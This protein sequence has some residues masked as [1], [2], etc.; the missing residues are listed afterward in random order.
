MN[1]LYIYLLLLTLTYFLPIP[2]GAESRKKSS[3]SNPIFN[4]SFQVDPSEVAISI[5]YCTVFFWLVLGRPR[6]LSSVDTHVHACGGILFSLILRACLRYDH[7]LLQTSSPLFNTA[8]L[9]TGYLVLAM[10]IFVKM[11]QAFSLSFH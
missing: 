3:P 9:K 5:S 11:K 1:F 2:L 7:L 6:F 10:G 8:L 4:F